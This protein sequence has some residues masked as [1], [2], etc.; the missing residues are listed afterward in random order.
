MRRLKP[1]LLGSLLLGLATAGWAAAL[2]GDRFAPITPQAA[3]PL[4]CSLLPAMSPQAAPL[5][6]IGF[7]LPRCGACS[8]DD[9][10]GATLYT[11]CGGT[12]NLICV[13]FG[14][15]PAD[16]LSQCACRHPQ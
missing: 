1:A 4:T 12:V 5:A 10:A 7:H 6:Q 14:T 11:H 8:Y 2:P 15:C 3:P 16:G 13:D 9:C